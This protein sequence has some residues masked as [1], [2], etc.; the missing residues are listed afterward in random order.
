[1]HRLSCPSVRR[2]TK[3]GPGNVG[4]LSYPGTP[5]RYLNTLLQAFRSLGQWAKSSNSNQNA[6]LRHQNHEGQQ[7]QAIPEVQQLEAPQAIQPP[8]CRWF[9]AIQY[10]PVSKHLC[11]CS[12]LTELSCRHILL[13]IRSCCPMKSSEDNT[14]RSQL[15]LNAF[16]SKQNSPCSSRLQE[17]YCTLFT[18]V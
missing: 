3:Q 16:T 11:L 13:L 15:S 7:E 18:L 14:S 17:G 6:S 2:A 4:S 12:R 1:M 8:Y 5:V 10:I 9:G